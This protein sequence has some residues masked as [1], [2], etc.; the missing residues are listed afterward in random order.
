MKSIE[1][2]D[3]LANDIEQ[4]GETPQSLLFTPVEVKDT[5][6]HSA[7]RNV[8][9][10]FKYKDE[11]G[12]GTFG[13]VHRISVN[14]GSDM[15]FLKS[16]GKER[17]KYPEIPSFKDKVSDPN[18]FT[19]NY[20]PKS[21]KKISQKLPLEHF[22][23]KTGNNTNEN[24]QGSNN[25][26]TI[27]YRRENSSDSSIL[28]GISIKQQNSRVSGSDF[29][30][31]NIKQEKYSDKYQKMKNLESS[32]GTNKIPLVIKSLYED[33]THHH[34]EISILSEINNPHFVKMFAHR[35]SNCVNDQIKLVQIIMEYVPYNLKSL[36]TNGL[37]EIFERKYKDG[38]GDHRGNN[39]YW[40]GNRLESLKKYK[41]SSQNATDKNMSENIIGEP[42]GEIRGRKSHSCQKDQIRC[43]SFCKRSHHEKNAMNNDEI[44]QYYGHKDCKNNVNIEDITPSN[45]LID[46][47]E[48]NT[49]ILSDTLPD[50]QQSDISNIS[51]PLFS[52]T[53]DRSLSSSIHHNVPSWS[54]QQNL[55]ENIAMDL[56]WQGF[57]GLKY[58]HS[59]GIS[60]RDIKPSNILIDQN[61]I[62]KFCDMGSA[63][64][65][66]G[67]S[68]T[69]ICSRYYRAPENILGHRQ[70]NIKIDNWSFGCSIIEILIKRVLF[71]GRSNKH[72]LEIILSILSVSNRDKTIMKCLHYNKIDSKREKVHPGEDSSVNRNPSEN[73]DLTDHRSIGLRPYLR[74]F[75]KKKKI[76]TVLEKCIRFNCFRRY[77]SEEMVQIIDEYHKNV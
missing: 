66:E 46:R 56:L 17:G 65:M 19:Q 15:M 38:N 4:R 55:R 40:I 31:Y 8:L 36:L 29:P 75:I 28:P 58:L 70:Y 24:P 60:H 37:I 59:L 42:S 30:L 77:S 26:R 51:K 41:R 18:S 72:Q 71:K 50:T 14:E 2:L 12:R 11:I 57:S 63:K 9:L 45:T 23:R 3:Q 22:D 10:K 35:R 49:N 1:L 20:V 64:R 21:H 52:S 69:Y 54:D 39:D 25:T 27:P 73:D 68:T 62:L 67:P 61:G 16:L 53:S 34:R 7:K 48:Q 6:T 44:V 13:V 5:Q 76:V 43:D 47:K 33:E 32:F 74:P